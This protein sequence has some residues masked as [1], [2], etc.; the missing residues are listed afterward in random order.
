MREALD[1]YNHALLLGNPTVMLLLD[2]A[3]AHAYLGERDAALAMF[4]RCMGRAQEQLKANVRD[5]GTRAIL[6]YC[7]AQTGDQAGALF[8]WE[9]A[10]QNSPQDK[11]V[12][13]YGVLTLERLGLRDR[14][15]ET[16]QS[17]QKQVLQELELTWGTEQLRQ[18]P[19][20]PKIA[21]AVRAR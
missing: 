14:A 9:Q 7:Q 17:V 4:R 15:L 1:A 16:L 21:Q 12:Q 11:N 2:V 19:R 18:D 20:Y 13:K 6:G 5:A 8:E 10:H 3:D